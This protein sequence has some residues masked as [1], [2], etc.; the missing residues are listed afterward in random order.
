MD[1]KKYIKSHDKH[2]AVF[3]LDSSFIP[4]VFWFLKTIKINIINII[5][6]NIVTTP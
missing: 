3:F 1:S 4:S 2:T 5:E 6:K